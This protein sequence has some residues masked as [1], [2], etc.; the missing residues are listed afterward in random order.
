MEHGASGDQRAPLP[1]DRARGS[2]GDAWIPILDGRNRNLDF[3][4][5]S[6]LPAA[7]IPCAKS[8]RA[9]CSAG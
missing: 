7:G 9:S 6:P 2:G 1:T 5:W 3:D 4:T 8:F